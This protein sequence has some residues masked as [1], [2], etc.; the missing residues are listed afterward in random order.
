MRSQAQKNCQPLVGLQSRAGFD[1]TRNIM[2]EN[3]NP[4]Q[5]QRLKAY[6]EKHGR[7]NA[8]DALTSLG[9]FR[10]AARIHELKDAGL[11]IESRKVTVI[12]RFNEEC[13]V[14]EYRLET[15]EA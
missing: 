13:S 11:P 2:D 8:I 4:T 5:C 7:I 15:V 1:L 10:L 6:L 12:N 9:I 14:A 3:T